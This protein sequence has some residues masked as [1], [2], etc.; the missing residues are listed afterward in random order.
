MACGNT[1][2]VSRAPGYGATLNDRR[3]THKSLRIV[4]S[5]VSLLR[6]RRIPWLTPVV[7]YFDLTFCVITIPTLHVILILEIK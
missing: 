1:I 6:C 3:V 2:A 4:C 5:R 7:A